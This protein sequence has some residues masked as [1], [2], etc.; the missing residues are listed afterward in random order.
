MNCCVAH[1]MCFNLKKLLREVY[2]A[3]VEE[4][5]GLEENLRQLVKANEGM[6]ESPAVYLYKLKNDYDNLKR[7]N[8]DLHAKLKEKQEQEAREKE[9]QKSETPQKSQEVL[10]KLE[11]TEHVRKQIAEVE[12]EKLELE[13]QNQRAEAQKQQSLYATTTVPEQEAHEAV[14]IS[15]QDARNFAQKIK[16]MQKELGDLGLKHH[17][18]QVTQTLLTTELEEVRHK[19]QSNSTTSSTTNSGGGLGPVSVGASMGTTASAGFGLGSYSVGSI[20]NQEDIEEYKGER[21]LEEERARREEI[22]KIFHNL[23]DLL[24][25]LHSQLK[26][27]IVQQ[28]QPE[29]IVETIK[30]FLENLSLEQRIDQNIFSQRLPYC[31]E[32]SDKKSAKRMLSHSVQKKPKPQKLTKRK[33]NH[34]KKEKKVKEGDEE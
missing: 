27:A 15:A 2:V 31:Q 29:N 20:A 21:E 12:R 8:E 4:K 25:S 30:K 18:L 26:P 16:K 11:E 9:S 10:A 24:F 28:E 3:L 13:N 1:K 32:E 19:S 23:I 22:Q 34:K 14:Y 17:Q 33:T 6:N 7:E 5:E